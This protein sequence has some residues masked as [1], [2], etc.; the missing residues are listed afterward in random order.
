MRA[1]VIADEE[2]SREIPLMKRFILTE[3]ALCF[4]LP[5]YFLFWGVLTLPL[6]LVGASRGAT[7][8]LIHALCS[9][10][11]LLGLIGLVVVLR[12]LLRNQPPRM[13]WFVILALMAAGLL[14]IW[15]ATTG[16]FEGFELDW[17][18][19]LSTIAP[20]L[21]T[22]HL[23]WLSARK[24]DNRWALEGETHEALRVC[25]SPIRM[26]VHDNCPT[27]GRVW[28]I[29]VSSRVGRRKLARVLC[30]VPG[31][32]IT[33]EVALRATDADWQSRHR[34]CA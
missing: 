23:L 22:V 19:L 4:S 5:A 9:V 26:K 6:W 21:C 13:P 33:A 29:E 7:Y 34:H 15:T 3:V 12:Y 31:L 28:S 16:Q 17:F 30:A 18:F 27:P 24:S 8:A 2:E 10:G 11:G 25:G 32:R 1:F 20:T 14:S